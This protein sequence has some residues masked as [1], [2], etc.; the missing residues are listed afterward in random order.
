M[1]KGQIIEQ[2]LLALADERE[3]RKLL[4]NALMSKNSGD[5]LA[6]QQATAPKPVMPLSSVPD[7]VLKEKPRA[8]G[9]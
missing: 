3:E 1:R 4:I 7:E 2:L 6:R 5:F 8:M 9:I